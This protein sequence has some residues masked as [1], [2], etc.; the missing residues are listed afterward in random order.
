MW[1]NFVIFRQ[2]NWE[3]FGFFFL[4]VQIRLIFLNFFVKFVKILIWK[5]WGKKKTH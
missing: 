2:I 3:N 5:K 1:R 4:L